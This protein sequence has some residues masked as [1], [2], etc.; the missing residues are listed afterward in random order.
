M[1]SAFTVTNEGNFLFLLDEFEEDSEVYYYV[2]YDVITSEVRYQNISDT[3]S[4]DIASTW[5]AEALFDQVGNL[6]VVP[7]EAGLTYIFDS[8]G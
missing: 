5:I 4:F 7:F 8:N 2:K 6:F 1:I 3:F